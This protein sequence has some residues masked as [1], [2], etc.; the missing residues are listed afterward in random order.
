M[1]DKR[2]R[3]AAHRDWDKMRFLIAILTPV[4]EVTKECQRTSAALA[5]IFAL[6]VALYKTLLLDTIVAPKFAK[7]PMTVGFD[8]I[9]SFLQENPDD[10]VIEIDNRLYSSEAVYMET[11]DGFE[12]LYEEAAVAVLIMRDQIDSLFFNLKDDA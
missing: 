9:E 6:A 12:S 4:F 10:D 2:K 8:S 11:R 7:H 3:R 5:D 1:A